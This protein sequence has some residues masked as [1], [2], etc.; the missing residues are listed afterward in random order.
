MNRSGESVGAAMRYFNVPPEDL[1]VIYDDADLAPGRIRIRPGGGAGGHRGL[2]SVQEHVGSSEFP[3]VRLGIGRT[4][5]E[6]DLVGHVLRPF[7]KSEQ[8]SAGAMTE[9]AA[10]AVLYLLDAGLDVAMN[11]YNPA[12]PKEETE[13]KT[14]DT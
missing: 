7:A 8:A 6:T 1:I 14:G 2:A 5:T 9:R 10:E 13:P 11:R 12:Q 3:R 4:E